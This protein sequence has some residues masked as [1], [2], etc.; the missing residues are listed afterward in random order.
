MKSNLAL[1]ILTSLLGLGFCLATGALTA[2]S[3]QNEFPLK[4]LEAGKLYGITVSIDSPYR[5]G[6]SGEIEASVSDPG[7]VVAGKILHAGDLDCYVTLRARASGNG[8]VKL[9]RRSGAKAVGV[10]VACRPLKLA[11]NSNAVIAALPNSTGQEAQ[12]FELRQ[13]IFRASDV[14]AFC[15]GTC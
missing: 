3:E 8:H 12:E 10:S 9:N 14:R 6:G 15:P 4:D 5:L 2:G 11:G 1:K 7:G 13:A